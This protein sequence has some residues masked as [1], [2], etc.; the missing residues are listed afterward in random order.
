M[1]NI[2]NKINIIKNIIITFNNLHILFIFI[3]KFRKIN[4]KYN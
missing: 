4:K 1:K 3:F 2:N